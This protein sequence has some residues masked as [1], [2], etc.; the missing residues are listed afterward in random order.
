MKSVPKPIKIKTKKKKLATFG[1]LLKEA[2]RVFSIWI[3]TRD[4]Y[5]CVICGSKERPQN[6]HLIKRGKRAVRFDE[7]NCAC[8][9]ASHNYS[10]NNYPEP[11]TNWFLN[12]YGAKEYGSLVER[13]HN[14]GKPYK[15]TREELNQIIERYKL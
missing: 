12:K 1:S 8:Q 9:C 2:D 11:Y 14:N 10:H 4:N 15:F 13:A 6:G 3:R 7:K 5:Q